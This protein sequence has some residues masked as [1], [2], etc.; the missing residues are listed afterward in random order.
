MI[1]SYFV[2]SW[3]LQAAGRTPARHQNH[4]RMNLICCNIAM[5]ACERGFPVDTIQCAI[6][7]CQTCF[8][9]GSKKWVVDGFVKWVM[10]RNKASIS[11]P[12]FCQ[13]KDNR[14]CVLFFDVGRILGFMYWKPWWP[15]L[16]THKC[17]FLP[18]THKQYRN[19]LLVI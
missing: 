9:W 19:Y 5:S 14:D 7:C 4:M 6:R 11:M 1:I 18:Q 2:A 13:S 8:L 12:V 16:S 17:F 3:A 10:L 15:T